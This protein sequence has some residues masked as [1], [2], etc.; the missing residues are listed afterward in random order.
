MLS[1][2]WIRIF[3]SWDYALYVR[4]Q[5]ILTE[6]RVTYRTEVTNNGYR[7]GTDGYRTS[8]A[9]INRDD[10]YTTRNNCYKIYARRNDVHRAK[11]L[12]Q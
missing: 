5:K 7:P 3:R 6:K 10:Y 8:M 4:S 9:T 12:L 1:I 2:R 11:Q